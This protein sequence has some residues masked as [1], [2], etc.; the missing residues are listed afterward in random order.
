MEKGPDQIEKARLREELLVMQ[1]MGGDRAAFEALARL[2]QER[3]WRYAR[4]LTGNEHAAWDV[5]Q[6]SWLGIARGLRRLRDASAFRSFAFSIVTRQATNRLR[7]SRPEVGADQAVLERSA[8]GRTDAAESS[9]RD[10]AIADLRTALA[11]LPNAQQSLLSLHYL[12]ELELWELAAVLGIPTGTVKSRL[13]HARKHLRE[14]L[15]RN[16]R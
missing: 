8:L 16:D 9:E 2:Y 13:H 1:A 15:E 6:E 12:E 14:I 11:Q 7:R 3:L 10:Q 4:R 5:L